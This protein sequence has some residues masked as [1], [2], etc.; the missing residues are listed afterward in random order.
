MILG[1]VGGW[2]LV[3]KNISREKGALW[4]SWILMFSVEVY[5]SGIGWVSNHLGPGSMIAMCWFLA[6]LVKIW[7]K[8][9]VQKLWWESRIQEAVIA[10]SIICLFGALNLIRVPLD[11]VPQDFFRYVGEIEQE[12]NGEDPSKVLLDYGTWIYLK[13]GVSMK[14]R[15]ASVSLHVGKNQ[16]INH[17]I[18]SSTIQR[19][20]TQ[21]YDKIL[22]R[23]LD[24][25]NTA[26]DFQDRGSGVKDAIFSSYREVRRISRV[27]NVG[28]WWPKHLIEEVLV[29]VPKDKA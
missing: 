26:Y 27:E 2:I 19:I 17:E 25:E 9:Q 29:F 20:Q 21:Q 11:P 12:F 5:T 14:D 7:P 18:L 1:L 3:V 22:A 8:E 28:K 13:R 4:L 16:P 23:Q 15:S 6:G 10:I 24:T